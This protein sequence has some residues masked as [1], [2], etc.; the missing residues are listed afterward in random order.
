M[1]KVQVDAQ[2][3]QAKTMLDLEKMD[4]E[5]RL[6]SAKIAAKVAIQDSKEESDQEIEGFKAGFNMVKEM[7][8]D[9]ESKQ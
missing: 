2:K 8:D 6:E 7:I 3:A 5:E 1:A 9:E 4:Q